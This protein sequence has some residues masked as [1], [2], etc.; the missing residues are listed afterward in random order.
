MIYVYLSLNALTAMTLFVLDERALR[1]YALAIGAA[2]LIA[3]FFFMLFP[4]EMA[5]TRPASVPDYIRGPYGLLCS[6]DHPHNLVPSLHVTFSALSVLSMAPGRA[7]WF[8]ALLGGWFLLI[9]AAVVLVHQ[10]HL[11]DI[12]GGLALAFVCQ[13]L[14]MKAARVKAP[15]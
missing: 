6:L 9:C 15:A 3:G 2:T 8:R 14:F 10:H 7:S 12:A 5:M 1:R 4:A 13:Q 11:A